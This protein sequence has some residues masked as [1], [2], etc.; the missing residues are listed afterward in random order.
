MDRNKIIQEVQELECQIKDLKTF[1]LI[2]EKQDTTHK[3]K[4]N[5]VKSLFKTKTKY[6]FGGLWVFE[7]ELEIEIPEYMRIEISAKCKSWIEELEQRAD[8]VIRNNK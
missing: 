8:N 2:L 3:S 4:W 6:Y 7:K 1:M 5:G